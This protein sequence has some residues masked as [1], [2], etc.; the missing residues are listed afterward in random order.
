M[1]HCRNLQ[2]E[3]APNYEY[4]IDLFN[5]IA[6]REG[7]NLDDENFDWVIKHQSLTNDIFINK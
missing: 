4:L 2:F 7:F 1:E 3:E 6:E 5:R